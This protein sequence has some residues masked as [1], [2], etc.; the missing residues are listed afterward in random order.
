MRI[1]KKG[2]LIIKPEVN[3]KKF[4]E[5]FC[6]TTRKKLTSEIDLKK[7]LEEEIEEKTAIRML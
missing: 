5:E 6:S 1:R 3:P 4:V 2:L 7:I